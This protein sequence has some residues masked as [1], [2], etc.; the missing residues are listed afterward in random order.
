MPF[1][2]RPGEPELYYEL[3]DFTDPWRNAPYLILQHGFGR[4]GRFWYQ[5]V[6][7]LARFYKVVRPDVRGL[8]RSSAAFDLERAF[9]LDNCVA[10]LAA[11]VDHLGAGAAFLASRS[12][13]RIP[14]TCAR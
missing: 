10:D 12:P 4:T 7:Y 3:D 1:L 13:R 5:W 6:P 2:K 14:R 9:T 8:G 11:I